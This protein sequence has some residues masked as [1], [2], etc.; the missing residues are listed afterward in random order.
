MT[1]SLIRRGD[2]CV[3]GSKRRWT[4]FGGR[5]FCISENH[6]IATTLSERV[7]YV[8]SHHVISGGSGLPLAPSPLL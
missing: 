7:S 4:V 1:L 5:P 2:F 6:E 8:I 3:E